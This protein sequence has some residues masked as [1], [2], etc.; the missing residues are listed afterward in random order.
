MS[1]E[2]ER[3]TESTAAP[4]PAA[5]PTPPFSKT[6]RAPEDTANRTRTKED[7]VEAQEPPVAAL[8]AIKE[9]LAVAH[10]H[11]NRGEYADAARIISAS[12]VRINTLQRRYSRSPSVVQL[13]DELE[14]LR[15]A[16]RRAC[17]AEAALD[18]GSAAETR[19]S[20]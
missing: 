7:V 15:T 16:N 4:E 9:D 3:Q 5:T 18:S 13:R 8:D 17:R 2:P 10:F 20:F 1:P 19:C 12:R 6:L 14:L 11:K